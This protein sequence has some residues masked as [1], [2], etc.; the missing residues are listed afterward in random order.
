MLPDVLP[1]L[2]PDVWLFDPVAFWILNAL[3]LWDGVQRVP[4]G[5]WVL[6]HVA[7]YPWQVAQPARETA[8]RRLVS[9]LSPLVCHVVLTPGLGEG[10]LPPRRLGL[11]TGLVR[12][13]ALLALVSLVVGVPVL[14]PTVGI[15]GLVVAFGAALVASLLT[16]LLALLGLWRMGIGFGAAVRAAFP[17]LSP[18]TAPRGPELVLERALAGVAFSDAVRAL[19]PA[20]EW[21]EWA[22][23]VAYDLSHGLALEGVPAAALLPA[24]DAQAILRV[25][26][27]GSVL[28]DAYCARCGRVY[29]PHATA[30]RACEGAALVTVDEAALRMEL[31]PVSVAAAPDSVPASPP[32]PRRKGKGRRSSRRANPGGA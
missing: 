17:I 7:G 13:P 19:L 4:A 30:C 3:M 20:D 28:G 5:A 25:P 26:P 21:A 9:W 10:R 12:V 8:G 2:L 1:E 11:W 27:P 16:A 6:R 32:A 24:G 14:T 23:P 18:F 22:R 15:V 29:L 31:P